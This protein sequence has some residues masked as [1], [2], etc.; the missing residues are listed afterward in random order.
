[1][2]RKKG[3][4]SFNLPKDTSNFMLVQVKSLEVEAQIARRQTK[5]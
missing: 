1:M 3:L 4:L 5:D 2:M